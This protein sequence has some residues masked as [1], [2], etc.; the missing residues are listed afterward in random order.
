MD[1]QQQHDKAME[2]LELNFKGSR[3]RLEA[4]LKKK[5]QASSDQ[6]QLDPIARAMA[7]NPQLTRESAEEMASEFGF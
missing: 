1:A 4:L 3:T 2:K 7:D 6:S 5:S